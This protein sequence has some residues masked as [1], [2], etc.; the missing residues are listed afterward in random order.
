MN[1][2]KHQGSNTERALNQSL[3]TTHMVNLPATENKV[4]CLKEMLTSPG[5]ITRPW[6]AVLVY[7]GE[8]HAH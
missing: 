4:T 7:S 5:N 8:W 2:A 1:N 6:R 3:A